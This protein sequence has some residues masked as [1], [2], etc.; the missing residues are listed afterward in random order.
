LVAAGT[1]KLPA[2]F[3]GR[4]LTLFLRPRSGEIYINFLESSHISPNHQIR[5]DELV[6]GVGQLRTRATG[7]NSSGWGNSLAKNFDNGL[8]IL[9]HFPTIFL[10]N[11][12]VGRVQIPDQQAQ[13]TQLHGCSAF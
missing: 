13:G 3:L 7:M 1:N 10:P 5:Y 12:L 2:T 11:F 4:R 8:Q 6:I 9:S